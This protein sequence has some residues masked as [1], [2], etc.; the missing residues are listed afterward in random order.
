VGE[1]ISRLIPPDSPDLESQVLERCVAATAF[2]TMKR[3]EFIRMA[4]LSNRDGANRGPH[5]ALA[6]GY[7]MYATKPVELEELI[8]NCQ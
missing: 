5:Q 8:T 2:N 4:A 3:S 6:S 7:Q 1:A